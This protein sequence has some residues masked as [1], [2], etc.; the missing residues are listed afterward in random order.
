MTNKSISLDI[1]EV[2]MLR[3]L[4]HRLS[5]DKAAFLPIPEY[6]QS[7][8]LPEDFFFENLRNLDRKGVLIIGMPARRSVMKVKNWYEKHAQQQNFVLSITP[9]G[10]EC[11]KRY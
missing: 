9:L 3:S 6:Y 11:L 7:Q 10:K 8:K 5:I 2:L 1:N 4:E